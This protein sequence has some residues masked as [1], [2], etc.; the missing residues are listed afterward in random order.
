II[1]DKDLRSN[2]V[3]VN[4]KVEKPQPPAPK[5]LPFTGIEDT[6]KYSVIG[7]ILLAVVGSAVVLK[8]RKEDK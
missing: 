7:F 3:V 5:K 8:R 4:K 1:N 6:T 2:K